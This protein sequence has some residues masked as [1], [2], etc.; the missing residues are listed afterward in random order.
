MK[1]SFDG[2]DSTYV[3]F[4]AD[5]TVLN[6][7][8]VKMVEND[9]VGKCEKSDSMIGKA[10]DVVDGDYAVVQTRGFITCNYSGSTPPT[11][12]FC[13]LCADGNGGV[14]V[15]SSGSAPKYRVIN[16]DTQEQTVGFFI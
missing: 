11:I 14:E 12:G 1:V 9:T 7:A 15:D 13:S 4:Y 2:I 8:P 16:V 5:S 3:T 6:D 10:I